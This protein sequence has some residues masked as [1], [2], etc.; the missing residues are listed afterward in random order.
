MKGPKRGKAIVLSVV[1]FINSCAYLTEDPVA[2]RAVAGGLIGGGVGAGTGALI[3]NAM[4]DGD[5]GMSALVGGAIGAP[6]GAALLVGYYNYQRSHILRRNE[7]QIKSNQEIIRETQVQLDEVR[8][9]VLSDS[10]AI[11]PDASRADWI[12]D[13][14]TLGQYYR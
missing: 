6:V 3:G 9:S 8:N 4:A 2:S 12:Y 13:G 11:K 7:E 5:V 1:I 10:A 14:P